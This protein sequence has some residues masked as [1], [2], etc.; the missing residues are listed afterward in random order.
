M[1]KL[2]CNDI[3]NTNTAKISK[4]YF[5]GGQNGEEKIAETHFK[6]GIYQKLNDNKV[7]L[8]EGALTC[9]DITV[10]HLT[11]QAINF[12]YQN[13]FIGFNF[14]YVHAS[15]FQRKLECIQ[16]LVFAFEDSLG[17]AHSEFFFL[18]QEIEG[19]IYDK[20]SNI[21]TLKGIGR[22]GLIKPNEF[23]FSSGAATHCLLNLLRVGIGYQG[24]AIEKYEFNKSG[25]Y[26]NYLDGANKISP[27]LR[28]NG[29]TH[30]KYCI[31]LLEVFKLFWNELSKNYPEGSDREIQK[32][33]QMV[34]FHKDL[35]IA[36][37]KAYVVQYKTLFRGEYRTLFEQFI[38]LIDNTPHMLQKDFWPNLKKKFSPTN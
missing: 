5:F 21:I 23:W 24:Q 19:R 12:G 14:F 27:T 26:K 4:Q 22:V 8:L 15:H 20:H 31:E 7:H 16:N 34:T 36:V 3:H 13:I 25:Y 9:K 6:Y 2:E 1:W 10:S 32:Y 18:E 28:L 35:N 11:N 29:S 37:L 38:N 30:Y 17:I 33:V